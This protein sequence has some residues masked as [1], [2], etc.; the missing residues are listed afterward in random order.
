MV[1]PIHFNQILTH[2]LNGYLWKY[3]LHQLRNISRLQ[4][5]ILTTIFISDLIT[6]IE[7]IGTIAFANSNLFLLKTE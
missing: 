1:V 7:Q 3:N 5:K 6:F 4:C 2:R